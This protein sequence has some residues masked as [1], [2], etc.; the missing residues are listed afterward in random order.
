MARYTDESVER[1]RQAIDIVEVIGAR[2]D[3]R[4]VGGRYTG[5]CPFHEEHTPSLS[6]SPE[7]GVYYCF[8]C[9]ASGDGIAFVQAV[10]ALSFPEAVESLASR[11]GI[12]L[13]R[14]E[15]DPRTE[16]R[17]RR[18]ERLQALV[19]RAAA[20]Y[21]RYLWEAE[22][23]REARAYLAAR[24]LGEEVLRSFAV[25][26]APGAGDRVLLAARRDQVREEEMTAAGLVQRGRD[27]RLADRFRGRV[28]F[29]LTDA[30][31]RVLG[32]GAR[33]M[34]EG[35]QPKYL[36]TSENELYHKGRHLFGLDHA[37]AAAA[38]AGRIVVV[39]GYT[40]VLALHQAGL[41]ESVAIM[42]TSL[43]TDQ[44]GELSRAART[45]F[46][47]LDAD[48]SGREAML[49]AGQAA[50]E[51]GV[52]LRV[53]ALPDGRDPAEL[54]AAEGLESFAARLAGALSVPEF[55]AGRVLETADLASA[56][57]RD[58]ALDEL[59]PLVAAAPSGSITRLEL[60]RRV[61]DRLDVPAELLEQRMRG[62]RSARPAARGQHGAAQPPAAREARS[63]GGRSAD[64]VAVAADGGD[65][66]RSA[67]APALARGARVAPWERLFLAMCLAQGSRG[68]AYLARLE[69]AQLSSDELRRA[70]AHLRDH[71]EQPLAGVGDHDPEL[72]TLLRELV[73]QSEVEPSTEELLEYQLLT[74]EQRR[75][76]RE[77]RRV[78]EGR[79][80]QSE[81][82][83]IA[84][85]E[86]VRRQ[87]AQL[88]RA[89]G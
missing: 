19:E 38:R 74:L 36:N 71:F 24:G 22:E 39:E 34:R 66:G 47:A 29:P 63:F 55:Q 40:D 79:S 50:A 37:R 44:L 60:V 82:D 25:G 51:R 41:T 2:S 58:R 10:E 13:A 48:S 27:G 23:A 85:R 20:Y 81:H 57:G 46:L 62:A 84:A 76:E 56:G 7:K 52:E 86:R 49:R 43:T 4:R 68:R 80:P 69:D 26:F 8:G 32:F 17:R 15:E 18:R 73:V 1:V 78:A 6:V 5:L 11:Y 53:V 89:A 33:A 16:E 72:L 45:I 42:G 12:E 83:L 64:G 35:Q 3:L 9:Q 31:G 75:I 70:A 30:R 59:V 77:L 14:E 88:E 67:G 61:A 87:Y 65:P 28:T 21:A 54:V